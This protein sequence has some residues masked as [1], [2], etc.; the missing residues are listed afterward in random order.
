MLLEIQILPVIIPIL[1]TAPRNWIIVEMRLPVDSEKVLGLTKAFMLLVSDT[2][3]HGSLIH[4]EGS[5]RQNV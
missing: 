5:E 4:Y 3:F 2:C 1:K